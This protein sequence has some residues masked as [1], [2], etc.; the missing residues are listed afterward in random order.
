MHNIGYGHKNTKNQGWNLTG[1]TECLLHKYYGYSL[2]R[3][4]VYQSAKYIISKFKS[5]YSN[6][7][8]NP[9]VELDKVQNAKME[10]LVAAKKM[11][12]ILVCFSHNDISLTKEQETFIDL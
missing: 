3:Q 8:K 11:I 5:N 1:F 4:Y 6:K 10:D 9:L 7:Y 12:K 2:L